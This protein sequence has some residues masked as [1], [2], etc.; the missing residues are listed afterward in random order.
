MSLRGNRTEA[1]ETLNKGPKVGVWPTGRDSKQAVWLEGRQSRVTEEAAGR[2][3][4][5]LVGQHKTWP[6]VMNEDPR[7]SPE[8]RTGSLPLLS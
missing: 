5:D 6:L 7:E 8:R 3:L 2:A 4:H 1:K